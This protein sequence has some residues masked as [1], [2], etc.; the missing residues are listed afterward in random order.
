MVL[1]LGQPQNQRKMIQGYLCDM[2]VLVLPLL[3]SYSTVRDTNFLGHQR[4]SH[5]FSQLVNNNPEKL[6]T[7]HN[8][9]AKLSLSLSATRGGDDVETKGSNLKYCALL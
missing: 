4:E 8:T 6:D 5:L 7:Q 1:L 3:L 9:F 2:C